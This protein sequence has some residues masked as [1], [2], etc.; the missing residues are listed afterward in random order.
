M[1][2]AQRPSH[3]KGAINRAGR[4]LVET[5]PNTYEHKEALKVVNDWRTCHAYPLNTF[6]STLRYKVKRYSKALVAQRLKRLPTIVDK[7]E[8]FPNMNLAQMQDIGGIRAVVNTIA[9]VKELQAEYKDPRRFTHILKKESDYLKHPK[10]DG[11]RGVH[12][13]FEYNNTLSRNGL[14]ADYKGLYVE[15]QLRTYLQHTWATAVE[16][17]GT[18]M[19]ESFKT[20]SG[21]SEWKHFFALVSSAFA[22]VEKTPVV[23]EHEGMSPNEIYVSIKKL[24]KRLKVIDHIEGLSRA[25]NFVHTAIGR[26]GYYYIVALDMKDKS[27][28]I[29]SF[30]ENNLEKA[31]SKYAQLE[32][33]AGEGVDQVLVRAG[34]LHSLQAA[35]PNYF[36]DM[37]DFIKK[38]T[39]IIQE[40]KE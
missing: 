35:Y 6:N 8:R 40:A 4:L 23:E 31:T 18:F 14:A 7:L 38:L 22:I 36:L 39:V 17:T 15:L 3:T 27:I 25:A 12:L 30:S 10:K 11:Y 9:Q 16:T 28:S 13:V 1:T 33:T 19:G 20:G 32:A 5:K 26:T 21:S 29:Y 37:K 24:E 2:F 34:D